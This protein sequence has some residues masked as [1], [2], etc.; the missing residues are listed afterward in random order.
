MCVFIKEL[1]TDHTN[2]EVKRSACRNLAPRY[3]EFTAANPCVNRWS[4]KETSWPVDE[5]TSRRCRSRSRAF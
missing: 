4:V 1:L 3:Y 5:R 2:P